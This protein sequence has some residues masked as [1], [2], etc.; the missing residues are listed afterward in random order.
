MDTAEEIQAAILAANLLFNEEVATTALENGIVTQAIER[1]RLRRMLEEAEARVEAQRSAS[2]R[3]RIKHQQIDADLRGPHLSLVHQLQLLGRR[4]VREPKPKHKPT[5]VASC[6]CRS[7]RRRRTCW[8]FARIAGISD[9]RFKGMGNCA[10]RHQHHENNKKRCVDSLNFLN[11]LL[12]A[13]TRAIRYLL[14]RFSR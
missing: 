7:G 3:T 1:Q 9:F 2:H 6:L 12:Q 8:N 4:R 10:A 5:K 11:C 14:T 13:H